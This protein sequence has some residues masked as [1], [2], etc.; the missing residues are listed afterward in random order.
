MKT[1]ISA[2]R[3][4]DKRVKLYY[5]LYAQFF[6]QMASQVEGLTVKALTLGGYKDDK[7]NRNVLYDFKECKQDEVKALDCFSDYDEMYAIWNFIKHNSLSTFVYLQQNFSDALRIKEYAQGEP[8]CYYVDFTDNLI[9]N[10]L[11]GVQEFLRSYCCFAFSEDW[12]QASWNSDEYFLN[13]V[14]RRIEEVDNPLG[15][16]PW[17]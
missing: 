5:S 7:F 1:I 17:I 10:I 4:A 14:W 13:E 16:P 11:T 3:A 12:D 8:A 9:A 2:N 15:L 6:Q